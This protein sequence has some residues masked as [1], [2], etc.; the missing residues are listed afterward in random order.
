[1]TS[2]LYGGAFDGKIVQVPEGTKTL[3][4]PYITLH[5]YPGETDSISTVRYKLVE[6]RYIVDND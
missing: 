2:E 5:I 4:V 6:G 3:E 1:M